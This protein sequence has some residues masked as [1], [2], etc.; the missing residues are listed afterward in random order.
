ML[1]G[2]I[3]IL[4]DEVIPVEGIVAIVLAFCLCVCL[5]LVLI[6]YKLWNEKDKKVIPC[7]VPLFRALNKVFCED[8]L[9]KVERKKYYDKIK[10][11]ENDD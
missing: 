4:L 9:N 10:K 2:N 11:E 1:L 7:L 6:F 8:E 5:L 3:K